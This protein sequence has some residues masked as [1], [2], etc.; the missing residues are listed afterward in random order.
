MWEGRGFIYGFRRERWTPLVK[1]LSLVKWLGKIPLEGP[2]FHLGLHFVGQ[3]AHLV[4]GGVRLEFNHMGILRIKSS[5]VPHNGLFFGLLEVTLD[6]EFF[7]LPSLFLN[8]HGPLGQV[9]EFRV[10]ILDIVWW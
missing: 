1:G 5:Q 4:K 9:M 3:Y 2:G 6:Q 7:K 10:V 8:I